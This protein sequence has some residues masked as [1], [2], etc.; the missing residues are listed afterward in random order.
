MSFIMWFDYN[1][2][3]K[4]QNLTQRI[5]IILKNVLDPLKNSKKNERIAIQFSNNLRD[6]FQPICVWK[7]IFFPCSTMKKYKMCDI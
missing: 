7:N 6:I 1:S 3:K 4:F 5:K 2:Y